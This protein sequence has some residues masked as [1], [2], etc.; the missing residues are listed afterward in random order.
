MAI[1]GLP[2][3]NGNDIVTVS[4]TGFHEANGLDGI[5]TLIVNYGSLRNDVI[6][7]NAGFG[8]WEITDDFF[9]RIRY[10]N[11]ENFS[12]T[13]GSGDD[14]IRTF[15][16]NDWVRTGAGNDTIESGLGRDTIDGG[17]GHDRWIAD[18]SSLNTDVSLR[19]HGSNWVTIGATGTQL[20]SIEAV[21]LR[22][23]VGDD[24]LDVRAVTGNHTFVAGAGNDTFMVRSGHSRFDAGLG[25][26]F[27]VADFSGATTPV[28]QVN[29]GFGWFRLGDQAGTR[30]VT[31]S[32]VERFDI[33]GGSGDDTLVGGALN[34][35]LVGGAGND[36]LIGGSGNDTILGG[37]GTDTWQG[38]YSETNTSVRVNLNNQSS[39]VST[40]SSIEAVRLKTGVGND[41]I[42]ANRGF[43]DDVIETG[44]GNDLI[45]TGRGRDRVDG[46]P[47][48]DTLIMDWSG[49]STTTAGIKHSNQGFGWYRFES[50]EGDRLDYANIQNLHLVGGAGN[51]HLVG[52]AGDDTLIG[53]G[54]NDTLD[55]ATGRATID[56]GEGD[57]LWIANL[58]DFN[59]NM[60][61]DAADSQSNAQMTRQG[62]S[63]RNIEQ[64]DVSFGG[65]NNFI[66]TAGYALSDRINAGAGNDTVNPGLGHDR[67]DGEAGRNLLILDYS[68]LSGNIART[69][70]GFG[71]FKYAPNDGSHSATYANFQRFNISGGSGNDHL[72]GGAFNDT[73]SGGRGD[74]TLDGGTGGS[75]VI[76]GGAGNDTWIMNLSSATRGLTLVLDDS[77]SGRLVGN[78]TR[79]FS[80]ENVQLTTGAGNDVI[81][82]SA[83]MGNH[84]ISTGEGRDLI[85]LGRGMQNRVDGGG[86]EDTLVFDASLA[87]AGVRTTN[88]GFGW[89]KVATGNDSY[90][91]EY[92]NI[93]R[94]DITGSAYNDRLNGGAGNDVLRGG[95][96]NDI[97]NGGPG[98]DTLFGGDGQDQF[99]FTDPR[100]AG[101]DLIADAESGDFLRLVNVNLIGEVGNGNGST[102]TTGQVERSFA[103]GVTTLYVGLD[104]TP[105]Y[106]FAVDLSGNFRASAFALDGNDILIL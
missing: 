103:N 1:S 55:S 67:I 77:G 54:G 66:S 97:L 81:D 8:W 72:I 30:S 79:L 86:G 22:T 61:F 76:R 9:S 4:P 98:N 65:G 38:D 63:I 94:L 95:A 69:N 104:G 35:R 64:L 84:I 88:I 29:Q 58:R 36:L 85:N 70:E 19:L 100:N 87:D 102:L 20:R 37:R 27:L 50:P 83:V 46:G 89:W 41:R 68:S 48:T 26:D 101:R 31:W 45:S 13:T 40:I 90:K 99:L 93:E 51:D 78:G 73:L 74:D 49:V 6:T 10:I 106:D 5:D 105:G 92:A 42:I 33:T 7:R 15:D 80:I 96:G 75:D 57:D 34:D 53:N 3:T 32:S 24:M 47:G 71:W 14:Y 18:Y 23:G 2:T 28:S 91:T 16:G 59:A 25:T 11:F 82:V 44:A 52:F 39:N 56:G 12:V 17:A 62:F 21:D 60:R 43:F